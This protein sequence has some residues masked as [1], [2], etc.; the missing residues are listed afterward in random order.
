MPFFLRKLRLKQ[1]YIIFVF[2]LVATKLRA[3]A[4]VEVKARIGTNTL[5]SEL[6]WGISVISYLLEKEEES[7]HGEVVGSKGCKGKTETEEDCSNSSRCTKS[8]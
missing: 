2:S 7:P 4:V 3:P 8:S 6:E 5:N 1:I